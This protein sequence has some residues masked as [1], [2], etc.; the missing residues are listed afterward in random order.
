[1]SS[2]KSKKKK[3]AILRP[4]CLHDGI[5]YNSLKTAAELGDVF[6]SLLFRGEFQGISAFVAES[7]GIAC[8]PLDINAVRVFG[9]NRFDAVVFD[10]K[11]IFRADKPCFIEERLS[12]LRGKVSC[13]RCVFEN[14]RVRYVGR[15]G[16]ALI[17][18]FGE[19]SVFFADNDFAFGFFSCGE[20][21]RF[22]A[23]IGQ[24][25]KYVARWIGGEF[26]LS[27]L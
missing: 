9:Q 7:Q 10:G 27:D 16:I 11:F 17:G 1:M 25:D 21:E 6:P 23:E 5:V 22:L 26:F 19:V 18:N 24:A 13:L 20:F 8:K 2:V 4:L 14:E 3:G 12:A 15:E